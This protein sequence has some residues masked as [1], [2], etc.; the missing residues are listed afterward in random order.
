MLIVTRYHNSAGALA[1]MRRIVALARD[2][3]ER[4]EVQGKKL[5]ELPLYAR[6]LGGLE[7][8]YRGHLVFLLEVG[9]LMG[10]MDA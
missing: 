10:L 5:N 6:T 3:S 2:Y 8:A 1:S 9:R 4:R 7:K